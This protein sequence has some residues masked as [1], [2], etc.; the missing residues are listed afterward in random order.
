MDNKNQNPE[1]SSAG[2]DRIDH[3]P[4]EHSGLNLDE[5]VRIKDPQ[6]QRVILEKR[7]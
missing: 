3:R 6:T 4:N 7:G 1:N 2:Q 5:F